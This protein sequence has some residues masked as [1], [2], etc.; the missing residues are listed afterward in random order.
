MVTDTFRKESNPHLIVQIP[1]K[2]SFNGIR[3]SEV[4]LFL[5]RVQFIPVG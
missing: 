2:T 1:K 4:N 5:P 3:K